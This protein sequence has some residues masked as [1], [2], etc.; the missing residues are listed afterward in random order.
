MVTHTTML[1]K[2]PRDWELPERFA[3]SESAY[4][5]RRTLLKAAG[6]GL[7]GSLFPSLIRGEEQSKAALGQGG[8]P[9]NSDYD[10]RGL[11]ITREDIV[12]GYNNFYEFGTAKDDP[13]K[14][15]N[16]GWSPSPWEVEIDGLV[17]KPMTLSPEE[18]VQKVGGIEQRVYRFRC[19]EAWSMVV[20]WDGF[21]LSKLINMVEPTSEAKFVKFYTFDRPRTQWMKGGYID[22]PYIEGLTTLEALNELTFMATGIYGKYLP[23][24][25]GAPLRLVVPWKYGFK[26]IK[27]IVRI[28]FTDTPP[29][30]TWQQLQPREYGFY[31]NVNP[32]VSHPRWSQASERVLGAGFLEGRQP[33]ILFNGYTRQVGHLYKDLDLRILF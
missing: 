18:I 19:V 23:N 2:S 17:R 20:P 13:K 24:Q 16:K 8:V 12:T 15:A 5:N 4:C 29:V 7:A 33:T 11:D 31:A 30:N 26:S 1:I 32:E 10:G 3:T 27:S 21:Q 9:L 25:N 28:E 6:A 14:N 22:W